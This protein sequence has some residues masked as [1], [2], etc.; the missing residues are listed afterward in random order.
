MDYVEGELKDKKVVYVACGFQHTVAVTENGDVYSWGF[1]KNGALGHGNWDLND[2]PK[3]IEG[4]SNI[5]KI[6]CG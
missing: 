1:G 5:V 3:K 6:E 2:K 4:L